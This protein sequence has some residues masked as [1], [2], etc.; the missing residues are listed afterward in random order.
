MRSSLKDGRVSRTRSERVPA[1]I[2]RKVRPPAGAGLFPNEVGEDRFGAAPFVFNKAAGYMDD[3]ASVGG[4]HRLA[5][6]SHSATGIPPARLEGGTHFA[7]GLSAELPHPDGSAPG[8][9]PPLTKLG[10]K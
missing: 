5:S 3:G 6:P 9:W 4:F 8:R 2:R 7:K 1:P 10:R